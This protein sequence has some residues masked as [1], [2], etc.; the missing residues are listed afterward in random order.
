[1]EESH[2]E[3]GHVSPTEAA[4]FIITCEPAAAVAPSTLCTASTLLQGFNGSTCLLNAFYIALNRALCTHLPCAPVEGQGVPAPSY[5]T[6]SSSGVSQRHQT[7]T[8]L[9]GFQALEEAVSC[10]GAACITQQTGVTHPCYAELAWPL[11]PCLPCSHMMLL[12]AVQAS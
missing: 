1:M 12:L 6:D 9:D 11:W 5:L 8:W 4:L 3:G 10:Y 2:G 7:E